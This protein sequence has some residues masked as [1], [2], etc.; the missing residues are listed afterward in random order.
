MTMDF[1]FTTHIRKHRLN[2]MDHHACFS[3]YVSNAWPYIK[4]E[5]STV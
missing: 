5:K 3:M 2:M 1:L 4:D